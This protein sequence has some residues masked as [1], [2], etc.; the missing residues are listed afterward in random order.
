MDVFL[1]KHKISVISQEAMENLYKQVLDKLKPQ[2]KPSSSY[3]SQNPDPDG[4]TNELLQI[5]GNC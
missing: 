1:E 4:F 3:F 2:P 5:L